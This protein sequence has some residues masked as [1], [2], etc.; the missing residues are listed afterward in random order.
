[1]NYLKKA[2]ECLKY[3]ETPKKVVQYILLQSTYINPPYSN[4]KNKEL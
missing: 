1:M 4:E 2:V 3:Y